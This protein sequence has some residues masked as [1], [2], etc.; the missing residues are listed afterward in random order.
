MRVWYN[1]DTKLSSIKNANIM[2]KEMKRI[3]HEAA[4]DALSEKQQI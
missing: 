1:L 2:Y 4:F 3:I